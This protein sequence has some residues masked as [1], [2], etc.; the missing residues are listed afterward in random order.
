MKRPANRDS[1]QDDDL[2]R[3]LEAK[4]MEAENLVEE[5]REEN[6][7]LTCKLR[8]KQVSLIK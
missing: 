6:S 8:K 7:S 3:V 1:N 4:L 2:V 5:Y